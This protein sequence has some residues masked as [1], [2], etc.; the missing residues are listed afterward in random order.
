MSAD[1]SRNGAL[2]ELDLALEVLESSAVLGFCSNSGRAEGKDGGSSA[3]GVE[4]GTVATVSAGENK[5]ARDATAKA[6]GACVDTN[7]TAHLDAAAAAELDTEKLYCTLHGIKQSCF[8][9]TVGGPEY[10]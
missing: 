4:K 10:V 6:G 3:P 1:L 7:A 8:K 5:D 9:L 2:A